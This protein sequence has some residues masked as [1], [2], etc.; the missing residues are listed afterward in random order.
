MSL[1]GVCATLYALSVV[2]LWILSYQK[3]VIAGKLQPRVLVF[4]LA[5]STV[6]PGFA[7]VRLWAWLGEDE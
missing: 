3:A 6:W 5:A 1:L 2:G 7:A 4:L